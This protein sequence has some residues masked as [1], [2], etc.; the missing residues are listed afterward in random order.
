MKLLSKLA[1]AKL[2]AVLLVALFAIGAGQIAT[3]QSHGG[4]GTGGSTGGGG[5]SSGHGAGMSRED[6]VPFT[7]DIEKA[8]DD[9]LIQL[10]TGRTMDARNSVSRL[11]TA[12]DKL[13]PHITDAALKRRLT[14]TVNEIKTLA[15]ARSPDLLNLED[16]VEVLR[17]ILEEVREKLQGMN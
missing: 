8:A 3:A 2:T 12:T 9:I 13:T 14:G 5:S 11:T 17:P 1:T 16:K 6:P 7:R 4:S 10:K 15:T